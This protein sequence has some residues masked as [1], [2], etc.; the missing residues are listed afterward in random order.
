MKLRSLANLRIVG[1]PEPGE[2]Q[3]NKTYKL[4]VLTEEG[5][6]DIKCSEEA[7]VTVGPISNTIVPVKAELLFNDA[8]KTIQITRVWLES[9]NTASKGSPAGK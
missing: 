5:A 3:G 9:A 4:N 8:Y 6:G 1:R 7:Y 2:Y